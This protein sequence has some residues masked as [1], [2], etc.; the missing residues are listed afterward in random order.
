MLLRAFRVD[1]FLLYVDVRV[2]RLTLKNP[3][4][5]RGHFKRIIVISKLRVDNNF[6]LSVPAF[7]AAAT[8]EDVHFISS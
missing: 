2:Q 4:H 8:A 1:K 6:S 7:T 3:L 5:T